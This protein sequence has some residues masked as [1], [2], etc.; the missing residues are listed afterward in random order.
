MVQKALQ[1]A[2]F[3]SERLKETYAKYERFMPAVT[4][5]LGTLWDVL[6]IGRIDQLAN[7]IQLGV[8]LLLTAGLLAL[9][10]VDM[11]KPIVLT[12]R[13]GRV[14]RYRDDVMHFLLGS[15]L[16]AFTL[17]YLKSASILS[18]LIFFLV[19]AGCLVGNEFSALRRLGVVMRTILFGICLTSY[20][21][22]VTPLMF[23]QVGWLPFLTALVLSGI[24]AS[25]F[26]YGLTRLV[27]DRE[28]LHRQVARPYFGV[29]AAFALF[30]LLRIIPPVPLSLTHVGIYHKVERK[31]GGYE[32]TVTRP[33][34][35][36]W[37]NGDQSFDA[38]PGDRVYCFFSVFSPGGF[39][40]TIRV[41]WLKRD[42]LFGWEGS[43]AV[44]VGISGGRE[45]GYRGFAFKQNFQPG[46]W[47]VR[48]ETSDGREI[49]RIGLTIEPDPAV[50][51]R[52]ERTS[53]L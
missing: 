3:G 1:V 14:M 27:A 7:L 47:Q 22:C 24:L 5:L 35:K 29:L 19:I 41:R 44:P 20:M 33:K 8:Y 25:A 37:Q 12:G 6:T 2:R 18:S 49:G 28:M 34:W 42:G 21:F 40:E 50:D 16:S 23:G 11:S 52:D 10:I 31:S 32:V 15:L 53:L 45:E 30:Y 38:R 13:L 43:D 51:P 36:F 9:E 48:I 26:F 4:F 46:D 17:F 39:R